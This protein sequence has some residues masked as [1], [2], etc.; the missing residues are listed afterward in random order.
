MPQPAKMV[1]LC[2]ALS[3]SEWKGRAL[4]TSYVDQL[5][6]SLFCTWMLEIPLL[7]LK[8]F[9]YYVPVCLDRNQKLPFPGS[10]KN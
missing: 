9:P 1:S 4:A 10:P 6:E 7:S 8:N 5:C 3:S 2:A